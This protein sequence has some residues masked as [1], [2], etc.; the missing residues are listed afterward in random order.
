MQHID[1]QLQYNESHPKLHILYYHYNL[2]RLLSFRSKLLSV[3]RQF[4]CHN[5][6]V[7]PVDLRTRSMPLRAAQ[8]LENLI[9]C[10]KVKA[11]GEIILTYVEHILNFG[12]ESEKLS[13]L[14]PKRKWVER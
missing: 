13:H 10:I 3:H 8:I 14:N 6:T 2:Q 7:V 5:S 4:D 12:L 9:K 11:T 1:L